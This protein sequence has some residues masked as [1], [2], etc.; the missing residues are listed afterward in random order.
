[1][2]ELAYPWMLP[3]AILPLLWWRRQRKEAGQVAAP[4][5]PV[6]HWLSDL[7]G[8]SRSGNA[9]SIWQKLLLLLA[10][11]LLVVALARP[12]YVGESVQLPVTGRDLLLAVDISPS[13]EEEDMILG[14]R[15][16]NRLT[17][18]KDVLNDFIAQREGD[19]LGLLLFGTQP[20]IQAPLS[21]DHE[22]IRTLLQE[23][24]LGMAGRATAI[25][26]AIGLA[27][28]RL[29]DRPQEQR[30]LV[31]LTD[32]ANTAGEVTPEKAAEIAAAAGVRIYTIGMGAESMV[33]RGFL[34]SRKV[35]P[36]RDLD[37]ELLQSIADETGGR[38]FRARSTPELE[39]IYETIN[40]L[41]PIEL[42]GKQYR[43]TT[44]LF[45]WPAGIAVLL[46]LV[47]MLLSHIKRRMP[48]ASYG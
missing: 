47:G 39:M 2:L 46:M 31:L 4:T 18:V 48:E 16:V 29:R 40:Q 44:D 22:T 3:L 20:Y 14:Q 27:V 9:R 8:V 36:S 43:P 41:E 11:L 12:Q 30:V 37:E 25:G 35:N 15:R 21:F 42:E 1:M 24:Q 6:G 13:M 45:Y 38:Y 26:D 10:W 28:K 33:Q 32:G 34:G 19:R 7:P 17:A 23:A 5:L